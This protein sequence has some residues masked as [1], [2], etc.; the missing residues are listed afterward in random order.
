AALAHLAK[1][2]REAAAGPAGSL[3]GIGSPRASVES[4]FALRRLVGPEC[5]YAGMP[6]GQLEL[7]R[8]MLEL[9]R[10]FPAPSLRQIEHAD[11]ALVLGEDLT[12]T[13]ARMAL[14]LRQLVRQQ[15][16]REVCDPLHIPHWLDHAAREAIQDV[17][18]PLFIATP[19][20]TKLD[21]IARRVH[22][23]A[24]PDI[25]RLGFAVAAALEGGSA[26]AA[27]HPLAAEIAAALAAAA[28]PV[29]IA[30]SSGNSLDVLDAAAAVVQ[31]LQ[32]RGRQ[33]MLSLVPPDANTLGLALLNPH[34]LAEA[35]DRIRFGDAA[36]VVALECDLA[37]LAPED[38]VEACF[39][40]LATGGRHLVA[41]DQLDHR[42]T[43]A[44][45]LALPAAGFAEGDGTLINNEGRAQRYF[46]VL[47]P[48]D[49]IRESWRWLEQAQ[50]RD[51]AL[52]ELI[53][54]IAA[55]LPELAPIR[56]AAPPASF[57][58][59]QQKMPRETHRFS[60]RTAIRAN[61]TVSEPKPPE[62]PDAPLT[63]T[64]EGYPAQ[65][66]AALTPFF[67]SPGWNSPQ[68]QLTYQSEINAALRGGDAG[69]LIFTA[70]TP[71]DVGRVADPR[72]DRRPAPTP[73]EPFSPRPDQFWVE[74][75]FHLFG[76]EELSREGRA[77][78]SLAPAAYVA[79]SPGDAAAHGWLAGQ[80]LAIQLGAR[81]YQV[82]LRLLEGLPPGVAALPAGFAAFDGVELPAWCAIT[83]APA[84]PAPTEP[85]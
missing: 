65:P 30:G 29:I 16:L 54:Q 74:R 7:A 63:Y 73:P 81:F 32:A 34:P 21:D 67:W 19:A 69:A 77:L 70:S 15:P 85:R 8:R 75:Q 2:L 45:E 35:L 18:G 50:G 31:A 37:R 83:A 57:R 13:A 58:L 53:A 26:P 66:P 64:M 82:P 59:A 44:A 41:L 28:R 20:P 56:A 22:R 79:L 76:S 71:S 84:L 55:E 10:V 62:D 9:L 60:G 17:R 39:A 47:A 46:Q 51:P 5:F 12:Q 27:A 61:L 3:I 1:R 80:P 49:E 52:D 23:A 72:A 24:T 43:R 40:R 25:A 78:A 48:S 68:A 38:E 6:P 14:S 4:N 36:T 11:A 33:A 42:T